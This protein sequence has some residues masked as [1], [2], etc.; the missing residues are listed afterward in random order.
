MNKF[1]IEYVEPNVDDKFFKKK[2]RKKIYIYHQLYQHTTSTYL[3]RPTKNIHH[4]F[5]NSSTVALSTFP[6]SKTTWEG[7]KPK[8]NKIATPTMPCSI[9]TIP[10]IIFAPT[11]Q[12]EKLATCPSNQNSTIFFLFF[13]TKRGLNYAQLITIHT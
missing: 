11:I 2:R 9:I 7:Q 5:Q 13:F 8:L 1:N 10:L 4:L 12:E 3:H 6:G